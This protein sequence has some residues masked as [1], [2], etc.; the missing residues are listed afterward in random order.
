M[1]DYA[2]P[3]SDFTGVHRIPSNPNGPYGYRQE[4]TEYALLVNG[5]VLTGD[6]F[7]PLLFTSKREAHLYVAAGYV[8]EASVEILH[9]RV[10]REPFYTTTPYAPHLDPKA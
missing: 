2:T 4:E 6:G 9:R 3:E 10:T 8:D 5:R 7:H 1:G